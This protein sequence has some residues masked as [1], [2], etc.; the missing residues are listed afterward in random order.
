M[1]PRLARQLVAGALL[2]VIVVV[3]AM[4]PVPYVVFSPGPV[5]DT[6]G[7]QGGQPLI[8]ISG[9]QTYPTSGR[10][11]LVTVSEQG[12]PGRRM[13]LLQALV[14]WVRPAEAVLPEALIYPPGTTSEQVQQENAAEMQESQDAATF[15]ALRL[16]DIPMTTTAVVSQVQSGGP[17]Q[18]VLEPG[19][20]ILRVDGHRVTTPAQVRDRISAHQPG[21]DVR[22]R[23][24]RAGAPQGVTITTAAAPGA[25][26]HAIIGVIPRL[27]YD[28]DVT[29][30][31][32]L[33]NVGG[34]S[35]GLMFALG[36]YDML[37][38]GP[39]TG[40]RHVA[41]TGT[42]AFDGS[43]GAIGGIQQKMHAARDAGATIFFVP[44]AN[45]AEAVDAAP[46][47]LQLIRA[48]SLRSAAE[49]LERIDD[50]GSSAQVPT[51]PS[52]AAGG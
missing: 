14:G 15:A 27:G 42:M 41:G 18:G 3:G 7:T 39:L 31:I 23:I 8:T 48:D 30:D 45:C 40:G 32:A 22:L 6:L 38:P 43:V 47:G 33:E 13:S 20:V 51:C 44:P 49:V 36:I 24:E 4:L 2:V 12:G 9:G 26:D 11:D 50:Q 5:Y 19:D 28:S 17:S 29:V 10:L 46:A 21:E 52:A 37:T 25:P 34:P 16:A 35:A 1:S